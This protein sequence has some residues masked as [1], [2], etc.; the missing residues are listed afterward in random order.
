MTAL[1]LA[2]RLV[3][4]CHGTSGDGLA[5]ALTEAGA[6]VT[7]TLAPVGSSPNSESPQSPEAT[8][9]IEATGHRSS[10][11][12]RRDKKHAACLGLGAEPDGPRSLE[13]HPGFA[14]RIDRAADQTRRGRKAARE[15]KLLACQC[16]A[17]DPSQLVG[18]NVALTTC[19][20]LATAA[21]ATGPS[22]II[23]SDEA[24]SRSCTL[25]DELEALSGTT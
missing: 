7:V 5:P 2:V 15:F 24:P 25:N 14:R 10:Y 13:R 6:S 16:N 8:A 18:G 20:W 22:Q 3:P 9:E 1:A 17:R 4:R 11:K 12:G 21:V 19:Q 23:D